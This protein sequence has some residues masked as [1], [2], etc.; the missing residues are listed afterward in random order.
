MRE[1]KIRVLVI[2]GSA[3][4]VTNC[5]AADSKAGYLASRAREKLPKDWI[6]DVLNL[7]NDYVLPKIQ[8][9]NACVSTSMALC[10]WPCN[11]YKRHSFFE[12]DLMWDED[13]YGRFY[14]ADAILV[15]SPINWYNSTS[16]IKLLF[17]RLVCMNGGNPNEKLINHKDGALAA[18][19]ENSPAWKKLSLNH[20]EGRTAGFF[21]YGDGGGTEVDDNG[22][23]RIL[24]RKEYFN[25]EKETEVTNSK[26]SHKPII[27]QC[28]Y[29]GIEVPDGLVREIIFGEGKP[30]S[31]NQIPELKHDKYALGEFDGFLEAFQKHVIRKG[32]VLPSQYPVPLKKPDS[33]LHPFLRQIQLLFRTVCGNLWLHSFGYFNS[34]KKAKKLRLYKDR[35]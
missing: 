11:C 1:R 23:P 15:C 30:Y 8:S 28:R 29:S 25:P 16:N 24:K 9:C 20:L 7:G 21:I 32:K 13:V 22:Y 4:R 18:K 33:D 31:K 14:A 6:V 3:R 10:I 5:P 35:L 27:W 34:R 2:A 26:D 17:D 19:L 12:P